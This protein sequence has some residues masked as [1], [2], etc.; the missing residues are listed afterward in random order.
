MQLKSDLSKFTSYF[1]E[2]G[3]AIYEKNCSKCKAKLKLTHIEDFIKF[4]G[5][6]IFKDKWFPDDI[7]RYCKRNPRWKYKSIVLIETL[8][9]YIDKGFLYIRN[10]DLHLKLCLK[11]KKKRIHEN[12][13]VMGKNIDIRPKENK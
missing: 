4:A 7:V 6:K 12:K 1:P 3:Q 9:N 10:I 11:L 8:Y 2:T 5:T 13:S